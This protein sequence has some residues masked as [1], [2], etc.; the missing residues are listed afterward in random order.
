M[1]FDTDTRFN[2]HVNNVVIPEIMSA[3][4]MLY[5]DT[6][7]GRLVLPEGARKVTA[8][9]MIMKAHQLKELL[10]ER[11]NLHCDMY[12]KMFKEEGGTP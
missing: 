2:H 8:E 1:K 4:H 7:D 6:L 9:F 3:F 12:L 10:T 11:I 5:T